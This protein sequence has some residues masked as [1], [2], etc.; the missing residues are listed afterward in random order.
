MKRTDENIVNSGRIQGINIYK[1]KINILIAK[2][3]ETELEIREIKNKI[4]QNL[5]I[6][7]FY[8]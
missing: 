6:I 1:E 7:N 5:K 3:Q 4:T 2:K 8:L